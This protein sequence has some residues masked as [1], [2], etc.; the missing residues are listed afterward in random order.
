[1]QR[2]RD[3]TS[4]S[5]NRGVRFVSHVE[6]QHYNHNHN[7]SSNNGH[8]TT[9]NGTSSSNPIDTASL[10]DSLLGFVTALIA[11]WCVAGL[12]IILAILYVTV[13]PFSKSTYRRLTAVWGAAALIDAITLLLPNCRIYLTGDSDIPS[14]VGSSVLVAN[15]IV[16]AD[17]WAMF[18]LGRCVGLRGNLKVFLRNEFLQVNIEN[19]DAL[20]SNT[21]GAAATST[22]TGVSTMLINGSNSSTGI[23]SIVPQQQLQ[24]SNGNHSNT[25]SQGSPTF[26][27]MKTGDTTSMCHKAAPDLSLVAKLL[28]LF[29][30]FP[31]INGDEYTSDREQLFTLLRSFATPP[32]TA[33]PVHLLLYPEC[34][35]L[36]TDTD[37][38]SVHVKSNS[39]A[40]REGK[41]VLKH[42]LLPRT[43]GFNASLDCLREA[44]PVVYDV[45]MV[46]YNKCCIFL[47]R[48]NDAL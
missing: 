13:R 36:H 30:E 21:S 1:M 38:K 6:P 25:G 44:S 24:Q 46:G 47:V 12:S 33:S 43:R 45:T 28:H 19:V 18:L 15:H 37:S 3:A 11:C 34:W 29:L 4:S 14:P 42:L 23:A 2:T 7:H 48:R 32:E 8:P 17:W 26:S 10:W 27:T 40:K 39:F 41:P 35:S 9:T 16:P 22:T 5:S 20:W 31:L